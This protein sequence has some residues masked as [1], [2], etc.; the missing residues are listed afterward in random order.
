MLLNNQAEA[1]VRLKGMTREELEAIFGAK[2][3]VSGKVVGALWNQDTDGMKHCLL[4][5]NPAGVIAGLKILTV[6]TG[7]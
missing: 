5:C 4:D 6:L 3:A 1:L 2:A 7:G